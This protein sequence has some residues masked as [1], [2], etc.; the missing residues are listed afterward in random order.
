M[1]KDRDITDS[2][3]LKVAAGIALLILS[4]VGAVVLEKM[5][6]LSS[7]LGQMAKAVEQIDELSDI[8]ERLI[9]LE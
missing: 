1:A 7:E 2:P 4:V 6:D 9:T 3:W 8:K 5:N